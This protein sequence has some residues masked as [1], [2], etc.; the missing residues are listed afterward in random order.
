MAHPITSL[1]LFMMPKAQATT[2][3]PL[4]LDQIVSASDTIVRG[5]VSE[6]W[7]EQDARTGT[8]W[9]HAQVDI[10][11]VLKGDHIN[12]KIIIEQ[13]GGQYGHLGTIVEGVARFSVGEEGYFFIE[14]LE[15]DRNVTVGMFQGKYN[16]RLDPY[17]QEEIV[18]RFPVHPARE[19][20]HRFIPLPEEQN[21]VFVK[22]FE[23]EVLESVEA[24][25]NN[26]S[27]PGVS[28]QKLQLINTPKLNGGQ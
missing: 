28:D 10:S 22:S 6:I 26:I 1:W 24:G 13:P 11:V 18:V 20:D 14:E 19:F 16:V 8:I 25:W 5:T 27:I 12:D 4:N 3:V 9:T 23:L 15:S 2:M 17:S 21:R 7:S